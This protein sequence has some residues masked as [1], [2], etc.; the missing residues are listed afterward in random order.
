MKSGG[1]DEVFRQQMRSILEQDSQRAEAL[2]DGWEVASD[3][4][5]EGSVESEVVVF[6]GAAT[7]GPAILAEEVPAAGGGEGCADPEGRDAAAEHKEKGGEGDA[8]DL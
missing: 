5:E 4:G 6:I 7:A 8:E 3:A 2:A 1:G